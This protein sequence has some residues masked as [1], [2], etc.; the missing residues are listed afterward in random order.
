MPVHPGVKH[1]QIGELLPF[2]ARHFREQRTFAVHDFVV[3][4][5]EDEMLLKRVEQ[6]KRDVVP[7]G[8]VDKSD[9]AHV[10]RESRASSPCS[11]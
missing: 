7:D 11:I 4:Q 1:P 10:M 2:V 5:H 8:T 6:R 3:A 9:R